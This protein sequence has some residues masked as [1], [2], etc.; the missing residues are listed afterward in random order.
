VHFSNYLKTA[1]LVRWNLLVFLGG[2]GF[3]LIGVRPDIFVPL[4]LAGEAA[5][6]GLLAGHPRFQHFVDAQTAKALRAESSAATQSTLGH[7]LRSL[8]R[9][10]LERFQTLRSQCIELRQLAQQLKGPSPQGIDEPL[11][12]S[13]TAGLDR[14]LWIYLRLL[15]TRDAL[16]RFVEKTSSAQIQ[17]DIQRFEERLKGLA[18][19][20]PQAAQTDR[21]KKA[22]EE[23]IATCRTRL[24]NLSKARDNC[25]LIDLQI[26]QLE[27]KIR[28]L[29]EISLNRQEPQFIGDQVEQIGASML[30]TE[31]TMNEL[32]FA[33]GLESVGD[34]TP[35]LLRASLT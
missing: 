1:F 35:P 20:G 18:Q 12:Q 7:I 14:L 5:Y 17:K 22:L 16:G 21:I 6:L 31:Q 9:P 11:E 28:S 33:T 8:P 2:L 24:D 3:A 25:Q 32:R 19:P 30:Q 26:E 10:V 13:Q 27:H 23:N 15:Y 4:V 34:D 29:S